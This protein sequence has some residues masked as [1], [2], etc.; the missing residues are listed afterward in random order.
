MVIETALTEIEH[1]LQRTLGGDYV[2]FQ[3]ETLL[4]AY[5]LL[6]G[7]AR[8]TRPKVA[9]RNAIF[10]CLTLPS[11]CTGHDQYVLLYFDKSPLLLTC[12]LCCYCRCWDT[13]WGMGLHRARASRYVPG[14]EIIIHGRIAVSCRG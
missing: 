8:S 14:D 11:I 10:Q 2:R 9:K 13:M 12:L 1:I 7:I 3:Y 6:A 4:K 5:A